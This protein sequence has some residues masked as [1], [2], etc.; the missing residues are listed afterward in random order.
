MIKL[1]L[2]AVTNPHG[3]IAKAIIG[4]ITSQF[5]HVTKY[6]EED[7]ELDIAHRKLEQDHEALKDM[8]IGLAKDFHSHENNHAL[9]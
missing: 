7:N 1:L 2:K 9:H 3:A 4:L 8:V 6:V 5:K